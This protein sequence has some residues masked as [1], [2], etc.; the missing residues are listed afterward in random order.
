[1]TVVSTIPWD[2]LSGSVTCL[3]LGSLLGKSKAAWGLLHPSD[4]D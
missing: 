2:T 1:M 3:Y 4:L